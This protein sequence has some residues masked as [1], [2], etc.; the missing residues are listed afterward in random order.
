MLI[1]RFNCSA[2]R[3]TSKCAVRRYRAAHERHVE[4]ERM[5]RNYIVIGIGVLLGTAIA[6]CVAYELWVQRIYWRIWAG[7]IH[8]APMEVAAFVVLPSPD[9]SY[10][11]IAERYRPATPRASVI[12]QVRVHPAGDTNLILHLTFYSSP[13]DPVLESKVVWDANNT[14]SFPELPLSAV[15]D[16][17]NRRPNLAPAS[18]NLVSRLSVTLK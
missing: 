2:R 1:S 15:V 11:A 14:L 9:A 10:V 13:E 6:S 7:A 18:S 12:T 3:H 16:R 5:K 17:N 4:H 8:T